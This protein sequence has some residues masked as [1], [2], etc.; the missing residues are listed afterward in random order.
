LKQNLRGCLVD[1]RALLL[2]LSSRLAQR[3]LGGNRRQSLVPRDDFARNAFPEMFDQ[4]ACLQRGGTPRAVHISWHSDDNCPDLLFTSQFRDALA[5]VSARYMN[6]LERMREQSKIVAEC[7]SDP[8]LARID[9]KNASTCH[10]QLKIPHHK[11]TLRNNMSSISYGKFGENLPVTS[12]IALSQAAVGFGV[13]LL[14]AGK[15]DKTLRQRTA[16]AFIGAGAATILPLVAGAIADFNNRPDSS[17]RI[18]R[19]LASIREGTGLSN[20]DGAY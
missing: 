16:I 15:L 3:S 1:Y 13:G 12:M 7:H 17:R 19:Q 10:F 18:R 14:I 20:G 2:G 9:A 8:S 11:P 5:R 4:L 6:G